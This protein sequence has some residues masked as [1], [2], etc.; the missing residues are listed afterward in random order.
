VA[1]AALLQQ[2]DAAER[3]LPI[4]VALRNRRR[5]SDS[6]SFAAGA[7]MLHSPSGALSSSENLRSL[8]QFALVTL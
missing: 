8:L 7:T 2:F 1:G 6:R 5:A 4:S 3:P